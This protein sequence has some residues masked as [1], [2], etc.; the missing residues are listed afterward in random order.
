MHCIQSSTSS[1]QQ[2]AKNNGR[3]TKRKQ[4]NCNWTE[5]VCVCVASRML[6]VVNRQNQQ[7]GIGEAS[8]RDAR[9]FLALVTQ[10]PKGRSFSLMNTKN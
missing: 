1:G 2:L 6:L 10:T 3:T 5:C 4:T 7:L 8:D 9:V